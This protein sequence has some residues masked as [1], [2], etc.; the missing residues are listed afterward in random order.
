IPMVLCDVD[1]EVPDSRLTAIVGPNGSGKT[2]LVAHLAGIHA[3]PAGTVTV[4]GGDGRTLAR[5]P[6]PEIV[7]FVFQNPEHQFLTHR[8][9]DE[10]AW[11]LRRLHLPQPEI[12]ERVEA[13]LAGLALGHLGAV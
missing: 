13:E 6:D 12:V 4:F 2:T 11:G 3:S 10:V 5:R 8:V 7:G 9:V 1:F